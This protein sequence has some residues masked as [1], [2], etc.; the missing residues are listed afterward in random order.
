VRN[1]CYGLHVFKRLN[2]GD[3][4]EIWVETR[5]DLVEEVEGEEDG[6]E[7]ERRKKVGDNGRV[8]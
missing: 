1:L 3:V 6:G 5:E 8:R 7:R 2:I 4:V